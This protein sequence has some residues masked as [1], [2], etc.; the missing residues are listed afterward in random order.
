MMRPLVRVYCAQQFHVTRGPLDD[1]DALFHY[2]TSDLSPVAFRA[3]S[4]TV[5]PVGDLNQR[6][7]RF[8][9]VRI[10]VVSYALQPLCS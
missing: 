7:Y 9:I 6:R 4:D 5:S 3:F 1:P 10:H 2:S 8:L